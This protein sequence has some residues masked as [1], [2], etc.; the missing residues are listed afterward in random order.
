MEPQ[1][2]CACMCT[3]STEYAAQRVYGV[4]APL[5]HVR[6]FDDPFELAAIPTLLA[7]LLC[8]LWRGFLL[9]CVWGYH[10][11]NEIL[12]ASVSE[13]LLCQHEHGH[14]ADPYD[15]LLG[16]RTPSTGQQ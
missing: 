3:R 2:Y 10:V 13:E 7:E 5:G 9:T 1:Q 11:Y 12:E 6:A 16:S 4:H 8:K 14:T 15:M